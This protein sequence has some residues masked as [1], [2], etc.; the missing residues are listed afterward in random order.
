MLPGLTIHAREPFFIKVGSLRT[1]KW[2]RDHARKTVV[3]Y[4]GTHPSHT[5][6]WDFTNALHGHEYQ[7]DYYDVDGITDLKEVQTQYNWVCPPSGV[8]GSPP[9]GWGNWKGNLVAELDH[10]NPIAACDLQTKAVQTYTLDGNSTSNAPEASTSYSYDS[11]G[12]ITSQ[13]ET[14]ND[15]GATGSPTTIVTTTAY[16]WNSAVTATSSS[17]TGTYLL[18]FP[19]FSDTEDTS[20]NRYSCAYTDYVT[21]GQGQPIWE[22]GAQSNFA[23]DLVL[24]TTSYTNCGTKANNFTDA[25]GPIT[26]TFAYDQWGNQWVTTDPDANAGIAGHTTTCTINNGTNPSVTVPST[27]CTAIDS[28]FRMLPISSTNALSQTA[29]TGYTQTAA[30]GFGLWPTSSTDLNGQTTTVTYDGL[31]RMTSQTL[32]GET[33]GQT[34]TSRT[35]T[36]FCGANMPQS[37]CLEVDTTQRL[38]S[39][40]TITSRAFYD[41]LGRLVETR[42]P[43]PNTQDVVQYRYYDA[44]GRDV[45]DSIQYF[46]T[47]YTGAPGAAAYSIPDSMQPGTTTTYTNLRS[48]SRTDPLSHTATATRSVV[49]NAPAPAI[50]LATSNS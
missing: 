1:C 17:A 33:S 35:Y 27:T 26:A 13:T 29:S 9:A 46:V 32:P 6:W 47:A 49:C 44:S 12:R 37:P 24:A 18:D 21:N 36:Y 50:A 41:G 34:T 11:Y 45:F 2:S 5:C 19:A 42:S 4:N 8:S 39:A 25:S 28:T 38:D 16:L 20:G 30:G 43:S 22:S 10:A 14:S 31:G 15:G 3:I 48:I 23:V 7:A 40:T